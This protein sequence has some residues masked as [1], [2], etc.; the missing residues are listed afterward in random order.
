MYTNK[1]EKEHKHA[2]AL[3]REQSQLWKQ[4]NQIAAIKLDKPI[5]HG[6]VRTLE[7]REE[8]KYRKDYSLIKVTI[9]FL[10]QIGRAHV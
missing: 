6:Y 10:G 3:M 4:K 8:I 9:E 7:L 5:Q 1:Y 2:L